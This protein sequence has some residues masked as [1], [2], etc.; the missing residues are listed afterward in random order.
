MAIKAFMMT[1]TVD[2]GAAA[3]GGER[4]IPG[5]SA[6]T[7]LNYFDG[8]FLRATDL[9]QE[10][11]AWLAQSRLGNQAGG[12]GV[13]YGMGCSVADGTLSV[14]AGLAIDADGRLLYLP[15][16]GEVNL[17]ALI[18]SASDGSPSPGVAVGDF[19][20]CVEL[21]DADEVGG[22]PLDGIYVIVAMHTEALCGSEEVFGRLCETA[23]VED[24]ERPY[25]TEG[26]LL[27]AERHSVSL[28]TTG[29]ALGQAHE[30]SRVA[31]AWFRSR[32]GEWPSQ[33]CAGGL[34]SSIWCQ[35]AQRSG[36]LGVPLA[37]VSYR[38]GQFRFIDSWIVRRERMEASPRHYWNALMAMRPWPT[39]LAEVL[40]FQCQ[41]PGV[42]ARCSGD[43]GGGDQGPCDDERTLIKRALGAIELLSEKCGIN[44]TKVVAE[45]LADAKP[46]LEEQG[47]GDAGDCDAC[48]ID[49]GIVELPSAGYLPVDASSDVSVND[50]VRA[51][52]GSCV[53]LRFCVVR[54][55]YCPHALE[56]AQH[57]ERIS[58][59]KGFD[60]PTAPEEVDILVPN[61][62]IEERLIEA[63][64][65]VYAL[66]MDVLDTSDLD[67]EALLKQVETLKA[68]FSQSVDTD[69]GIADLDPSDRDIGGAARDE[70]SE[71]GAYL[72]RLAGEAVPKAL[73]EF[74]DVAT[75]RESGILRDAAEM[76][77]M[78]A[79]RRIVLAAA[80][81]GTADA[82]RVAAAL[83]EKQKEKQKEAESQS[84]TVGGLQTNVSPRIGVPDE[85]ALQ[86]LWLEFDLD[87]NP[88]LLED[89]E[90]TRVVL[91]LMLLTQVPKSDDPIR[92]LDMQLAGDLT[93]VRGLTKDGAERVICS[94]ELRG[95]ANRPGV[96]DEQR[97][98]LYLNGAMAVERSADGDELG[99]TLEIKDAFSRAFNGT[100][101]TFR[102]AWDSIDAST[103][104][105]SWQQRLGDRD[106][107]LDLTAGSLIVDADA[108]RP[109]DDNHS[110]ALSALS[111]MG[112][113]LKRP[114]FAD[115]AAR[116]LFP[117]A[118]LSDERLLVYAEEPWVLF[119]RRRDKVCEYDAPVVEPLPDRV[120]RLF[121]IAAKSSDEVARLVKLLASG[122]LLGSDDFAT[123]A[124]ADVTF[125][126]GLPSLRTPRDTLLGEWQ[127]GLRPDAE[128]HYAAVA[129]VGGAGDEGDALA[130]ARLGNVVGVVAAASPLHANAG[131]EVLADAPSGLLGG[132]VDG[133]MVLIT[134]VENVQVETSCHDVYVMTKSG[135]DVAYNML[136][137]IDHATALA[138]LSGELLLDNVAFVQGTS[139]MADG[140]ATLE[141]LES[142]W[143]KR[144]P[145]GATHYLAT[146]L[147]LGYDSDTAVPSELRDQST[148]IA[149]AVGAG[150]GFKGADLL[151]GLGTR[152]PCASV[153][154][155]F[156]AEDSD[157]QTLEHPV[158]VS[159][160][161]SPDISPEA[162]REDRIKI[163]TA[164]SWVSG[165]PATLPNVRP[166]GMPEFVDVT[167]VEGELE[168]VAAR[169]VEI[170]LTGAAVPDLRAYLA[171]SLVS[172][173]QV[174]A[175]GGAAERAKG[176][177]TAIL[178]AVFTASARPN[179]DLVT[180]ANNLPDDA[181]AMTLIIAL[182]QVSGTATLTPGTTVTASAGTDGVLTD[183]PSVSLS[184][185]AGSV[186]GATLANP[187][188]RGSAVAAGATVGTTERPRG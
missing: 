40:Q 77:E 7:R 20:D 162:Y 143:K 94:L 43:G 34:R 98:G 68:R 51:L 49:G 75:E 179:L 154:L 168:P 103:F 108:A 35:P 106:L 95:D 120:Y 83:K 80:D 91:R 159:Y 96:D 97:M 123:P 128:I 134:L 8:K 160:V 32:P 18:G 105:L 166:L 187:D 99:F 53:D 152:S 64:G 137:E 153:T 169:A 44:A 138:Q 1:T 116:E 132:A 65:S 60:D 22:T 47:G 13:V 85:D 57:M 4:I 178:D 78:S 165:F 59:L 37:L 28:A 107:M 126:S 38:G 87:A 149:A 10:Q 176:Q 161:A 129:S 86:S 164:G 100:V 61:G 188:E 62:R 30:R 12:A 71:D 158:Y 69:L 55:D 135:P 5:N 84:A 146:L 3:D 26:V 63:P 27:R 182:D 70:V 144:F 145:D 119:H 142:A 118:E 140:Q 33:I 155:L 136:V 173:A 56:E 25:R 16:D 104:R 115:A 171:F 102:R 148:A 163:L 109:G 156:V 76:G 31:S 19:E 2:Q 11:A 6:L 73:A 48:L 175:D 167:P 74:I 110:A 111:R 89:G 122:D 66:S 185:A 147:A 23:C 29:A 46:V 90:R 92:L 15:S 133:V 180:V 14:G 117:P 42:M 174:A 113:E 151:R 121:R 39:F 67:R 177:S 114:E 157:D 82:E 41:L 141:R 127:S 150:P 112:A 101:L 172:Q 131:T 181:L 130:L 88:L 186:Y 93:R 72:L 125:V 45:L 139:Q 17:A 52:L 81:S 21:A 24:S 79:A 184:G 170:G 183:N 124:V 54:P 50:Q 9:Q 58:L 36:A